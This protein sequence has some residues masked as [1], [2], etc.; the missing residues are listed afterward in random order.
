[1]KKYIFLIMIICL[2]ICGY[3]VYAEGE[4]TLKNIKVNGR[5]CQCTDYNCV[6]EIDSNKATVTYELVDSNA[7]VDRAS[8]FSVDI[9]SQITSVKITV[10]NTLNDEKRENSYNITINKHERS[11]DYTLSALKVN[12]TDIELKE[13]VYVY[14]YTAKYDEDKINITATTTD[15]NARIKS[16]LEQ[17]FE[18]DRSSAAIDFDV[19]AEN[20]EIKTYRIVVSRGEKPDTTLKS[21]KIDHGEINFDKNVLEY[22]FDV[23]YSVND[24]IIEALQNDD[25]ATVKIEKDD[26]VVGENTIKIIVTNE[27]AESVYTLLVNR[28]PN[29]DKSL[30][31]LQT[32]KVDEYPKLGFEENVLEYTLKFN[33]I[34]QELTI[35]AKPISSD[36]KVEIIGNEELMDKDKVIVKVTLIETGITR[37]YVL[38]IQEEKGISNNKTFILISI[39]I[40]FITMLVMFILE[41]KEKKKKRWIKLNYLKELKKK[42]KSKVVKKEE[43]KEEEIEII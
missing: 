7:Q 28:L 36:G 24:L 30:A 38:N 26:L 5:E 25:K 37:E 9:D 4:A 35:T 19:E 14:S 34:P 16:K 8:G 20:G 6:I 22:K 31:N 10:S 33:E 43:K 29:M 42:K 1:M 13:E 11:N 27:K 17:D 39:L 23:E 41:M 12:E 18:L 3:N 40:V 21:L 15:S 2:L 32:L